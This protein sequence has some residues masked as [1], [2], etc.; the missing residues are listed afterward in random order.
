MITFRAPF[1]K[2]MPT[3]VIPR[4]FRRFLKRILWMSPFVAAIVFYWLQVE[5]P[6]PAPEG[7]RHWIH[8]FHDHVQLV[9]M[10]FAYHLFYPDSLKWWLFFGVIFAVCT[11]AFALVVSSNRRVHI[12]VSRAAVRN[13]RLY[14]ILGFFIRQFRKRTFPQHLLREVMIHEREIALNR[15]AAGRLAGGSHKRCEALAN[16]TRLY[17]L[18]FPG[19][20]ASADAYFIAASYWREAVAWMRLGDVMEGGN[21]R[22]DAFVRE[23]APLVFDVLKPIVERT[24]GADFWETT[25]APAGFDEASA[26]VDLFHLACYHHPD[27]AGKTGRWPLSSQPPGRMRPWIAQRLFES[28]SARLAVMEEM[29]YCLTPPGLDGRHLESLPSPPR[30]RMQLPPLPVEKALLP[31]L[32]ALGLGIAFDLAIMADEPEI[33]LGYMDAI[34]S[35]TFALEIADP[36]ATGIPRGYLDKI[37]E[38]VKGL[39]RTADRRMGA[40]LAER[41]HERRKR[42]WEQSPLYESGPLLEEDFELDR[43]RIAS[44][45]LAAGPGMDKSKG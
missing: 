28:T 27:L 18:S 45:H 2:T 19:P 41:K 7:W 17:L 6:T 25:S 37:A 1:L 34:E 33:A 3:A 38:L 24:P 12:R 8:W 22:L 4:R 36:G 10:G 23:L 39:P 44:L 15:V 35:I 16:V 14:P 30:K 20:S 31:P 11:G 5:H 42:R 13:A 9:F 26:A 21:D 40:I 29:L 32:G 43:S